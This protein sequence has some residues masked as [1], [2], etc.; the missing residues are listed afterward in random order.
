MFKNFS[1]SFHFKWN[2]SIPQIQSL[3]LAAVCLLI[4]LFSFDF[5]TFRRLSLF[6]WFFYSERWNSW[7]SF[8]VEDRSGREAHE[9]LHRRRWRQW[10]Q[11]TVLLLVCF[12]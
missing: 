11:L 10:A 8:V 4:D 3:M 1:F 2:F 6:L 9:D 12:H 7:P 5:L